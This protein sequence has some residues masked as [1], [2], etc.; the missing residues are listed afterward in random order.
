MHYSVLTNAELHCF[1]RNSRTH[2]MITIRVR[3]TTPIEPNSG[4]QH[5][6]SRVVL[7]MATWGFRERTQRSSVSWLAP[8]SV[9]DGRQTIFKLCHFGKEEWVFAVREE[10]VKGNIKLKLIEW[11][12]RFSIP[13]QP[14]IAFVGFPV[15][16]DDTSIIRVERLLKHTGLPMTAVR[17]N[18][19]QVLKDFDR[20]LDNLDK[21]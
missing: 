15:K 1:N 2:S 6:A 8:S 18:A 9:A 17:E 5:L 11:P 21:S 10:F 14:E 16:D 4:F 20:Q 3:K 13:P 7:L 19:V 12:V